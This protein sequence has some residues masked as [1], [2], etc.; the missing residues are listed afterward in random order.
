MRIN[1][2]LKLWRKLYKKL[3]EWS[4]ACWVFFEIFNEVVNWDGV[5]DMAVT[6]HLFMVSGRIKYSIIDNLDS[7]LVIPLNGYMNQHFSH[8]TAPWV[9]ECICVITK[10]W[11][12]PIDT[13][14]MD[15]S[16][17]FQYLFE[18]L[19][20]WSGFCGPSFGILFRTVF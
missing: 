16:T 18:R 20:S 13:M 3:E 7:L 14:E 5:R 19:C 10:L 11:G 9:S 15:A 12:V 1:G 6:D 2:L 4:P 8:D 17:A